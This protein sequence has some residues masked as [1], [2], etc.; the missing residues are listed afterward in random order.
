M[1]PAII[2]LFVITLLIVCV[3]GQ[4]DMRGVAFMI[5]GSIILGYYLM[6]VLIKENKTNNFNK[7]YQSVLMG[8]SM[9]ALEVVSMLTIMPGGSHSKKTMLAMLVVLIILA[10]IMIVVIR[11]QTGIDRREFLLSMIEH[12]QMAIDMAKQLLLKN[13]E[14]D[15]TIKLAN[16][17][18]ATQ[19]NEIEEMRKMLEN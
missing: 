6:T 14:D 7:W 18:I 11:N 8:L 2:I 19:T 17:I 1:Q 16:S 12:H 13:P 10:S 9:G 15:E 4:E 3:P 5:T